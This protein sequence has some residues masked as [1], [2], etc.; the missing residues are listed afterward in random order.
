MFYCELTQTY[1]AYF[2]LI[3]WTI[4]YHTQSMWLVLVLRIYPF[5]NHTKVLWPK[6]VSS[7]YN[8]TFKV[9]HDLYFGFTK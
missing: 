9:Y 1:R 5:S 6:F 3:L 7:S 4:K 8:A 2:V